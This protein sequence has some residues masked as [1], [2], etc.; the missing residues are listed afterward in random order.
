MEAPN[1]ITT[2]LRNTAQET[3]NQTQ[4]I[5]SEETHAEAH[6]GPHIPLIQWEFVWGYIS[7]VTITTF[8]FCIWVVLV[9]LKAQKVLRSE[10]KSYLKLF[11]LSFVKFFDD[12]L[13]DSFEDK[14]LARD[15]FPL[16]VGTFFIVFFGNLF[17]LA[18][19]WV[20]SSISPTLFEYMRPMH[21]DLNTTLVLAMITVFSFLAVAVKTHGAG[22]TIKS[23][24]FNFTGHTLVEKCINVFVGWLHLI[25]LPATLASLS[26]RL[27]G[28]IFAGI[29][30]IG[31]ISFLWAF[32][33]HNVFEIGRFL[34][35]PFWFFEFFVALVQ[36]IVFSFLIIAYI[37]QS[38]TEH[39]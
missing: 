16:I 25:G 29:V 4:V 7:N 32:F 21:S 6:T 11:F 14:T 34:S 35:I 9:S 28:N 12:L 37:K 13:R 2:D 38:Q 39:H 19:D 30:L 15:F 1:T 3:S 24:L 20:G 31:V 33:S 36:A 22:G 27:F 10:K 8:V 18:I 23:Y 17:G 26:L 5:T